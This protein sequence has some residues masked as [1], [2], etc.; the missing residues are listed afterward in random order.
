MYIYKPNYFLGIRTGETLKSSKTFRIY[1]NTKYNAYMGNA[2][3]GKR[4]YCFST[5]G[6]YGYSYGSI[7]ADPVTMTSYQ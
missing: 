4:F 2:G 3:A 5:D 7:E 6:K 1:Q